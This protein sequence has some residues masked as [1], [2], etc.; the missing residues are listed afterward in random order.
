MA[1]M[2]AI[3][4]VMMVVV[5]VMAMNMTAFCIYPSSPKIEIGAV[6][7]RGSDYIK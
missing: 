1:V 3:I 2:M 4:M 6:I 5:M 7:P